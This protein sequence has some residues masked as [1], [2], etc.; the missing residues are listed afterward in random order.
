MERHLRN[1]LYKKVKEA[2]DYVVLYTQFFAGLQR[3]NS[4]YYDDGLKFLV[5]HKELI[6]DGKADRE[7]FSPVA[8]ALIENIDC[9]RHL[10]EVMDRQ[11]A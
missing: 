11:D 2:V 4:K 5:E 1:A 3:I 9:L 10:S 7:A 6:N 8:K